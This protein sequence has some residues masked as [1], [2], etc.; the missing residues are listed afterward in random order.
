VDPNAANAKGLIKDLEGR[1]A[2]T[3]AHYF[4]NPV[5]VHHSVEEAYFLWGLESRVNE[6]RFGL[7]RI[8]LLASTIAI[9]DLILMLS[10]QTISFTNNDE[11]PRVWLE[12]GIL[13]SILGF[14]RGHFMTPTKSREWLMKGRDISSLIYGIWLFFMLLNINAIRRFSVSLSSVIHNTDLENDSP[15]VLYLQ[16]Y[17]E[18]STFLDNLL[19]NFGDQGP[20]PSEELLPLIPHSLCFFRESTKTRNKASISSNPSPLTTL[21]RTNQHY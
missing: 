10:S 8:I 2:V 20:Y 19:I 12:L 18:L 1:Y 11:L 3:T 15:A 4:S 6:A 13:L 21:A 16:P 7:M 5:F 9:A 14:F 17:E